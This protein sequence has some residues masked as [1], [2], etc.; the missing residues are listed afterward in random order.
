MTTFD[1]FAALHVP[2]APL[3]LV[4]AW[5]VCS[6][7]ALARAGHPA[8]GTTSLG[9]TA[10][11]GE[12]DG[13]RHGSELTFELARRLQGRLSVPLSVDLEDGYGDEPG[14]VSDLVSAAADLGVVGVNLEDARRPAPEHAA[15]VA[16]VRSANDGVFLNARTDEFWSGEHRLATALERCRAYR[17]A[18]AHGLFVP[19]LADPRDLDAV[20]GLGLPVNILWHQGVDLG[21]TAAARVST[22]S[23]LYRSALAAAL[24]AADAAR[25]ERAP[26]PAL[27][28]AETQHLLARAP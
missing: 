4:N 25:S 23:L 8:I 18:G 3:L 15:I 5:D 13:A 7:L 27:D 21:S 11:A 9:L 28:Y 24:C 12:P 26:P 22:G 6:A 19:G 14:A 17:D 2:G 10:A 16:A 1:A 20:A